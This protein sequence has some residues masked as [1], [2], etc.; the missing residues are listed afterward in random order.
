MQSTSIMDTI[1]QRY[2]C[3][4]YEKEPIAHDVQAQIQTYL[5][6]L[7]SGPFGTPIRLALTAAESEDSTAL[8]GLGTYGFIKNATGFIIGTTP[9][10]WNAPVDYGYVV[11]KAVLKATTLGLGTCWL[12]GTFTKSSFAKK[13]HKQ[14][15]EIIPAVIATG[16]PVSNSRSSDA[17]RKRIQ[18]DRR[19]PWEQLFFDRQFGVSL[20]AQQAGAY[21]QPL[22]ML[23]LGPSASNKQPWRVIR[24]GA[25]WHFYC[26]RTPGYGKGSTLFGLMKLADLQRLDV[27]I[28]MAHFALTAQEMGLSGQW[29]QKDPGLAEDQPG[30][31]YIATWQD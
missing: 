21:Q 14:D 8:R 17:L 20:S 7:T 19:L 22:A 4:K 30:R 25:D 23:R 6:T 13:I 24:D 16:Y 29:V 15:D 9:D 3:R 18:A 1:R 26:E 28:G 10:S 27:G 31:V 5:D 2:S 12:G 11:E